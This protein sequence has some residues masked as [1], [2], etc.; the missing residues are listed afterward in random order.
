[1]QS[2]RTFKDRLFLVLKGLGMGAANKVPGV[3]GGVV[4]FVAGF[5]EEFI[6][7]LQRV[8]GIAFKLLFNGR[9]KS[10]VQ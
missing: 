8:N 3:S 2:T 6:Y 4:A 10:F 7:S 1:M 9:F 5:Y